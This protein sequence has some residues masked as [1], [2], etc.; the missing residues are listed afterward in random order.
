MIWWVRY[1]NSE[2][3]NV[4]R[5]SS[6]NSENNACPH[7]SDSLH[8]NFIPRYLSTFLQIENRAWG[9]IQWNSQRC[10]FLVVLVHFFRQTVKRFLQTLKN[11]VSLAYH[12]TCYKTMLHNFVTIYWYP[13]IQVHRFWNSDLF[14][15]KLDYPR[16]ESNPWNQPNKNCNLKST[17]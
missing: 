5:F 11:F 9:S 12:K 14:N 10:K 2:E 13:R 7:K 6:S 15:F 3:S 1:F 16:Y 4:G 17:I 8:T